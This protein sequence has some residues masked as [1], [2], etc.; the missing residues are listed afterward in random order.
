MANTNKSPSIW[1]PRFSPMHQD[2]DDLFSRL[3]G[4]PLATATTPAIDVSE[5][6]GTI[7][8]TADV[9]G[10]AAD[11]L[12]VAV[13]GKTLILKGETKTE[14]DEK[15]EKWHIVERRQG[16]FY[17]A[18]PLGFE[19]DPNAVDANVKDGVLTLKIERPE[20][21]E[22]TTRKMEIKSA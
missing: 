12:E 17:R 19:P 4:K 2:F 18:I 22:E 14:R 3:L 9:P 13:E 21:V 7:L 16:S 10:V 11:D 15:D 5:V 6:E 20:K 1:S 8:I